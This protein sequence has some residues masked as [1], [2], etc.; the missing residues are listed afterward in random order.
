MID[1]INGFDAGNKKEKYFL[2]FRLGTLTLLEIKWEAKK[3]FYEGL[4]DTKTTAL[5]KDAIDLYGEYN[6]QFEDFPYSYEDIAA[7]SNFLGRQG[8]REY[9]GY[10][11]RDGKPLEEVFPTKYGAKAKQANKTP[12]EYLKITRPYYTRS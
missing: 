11:L 5:Q 3:R 6:M 9:F 7:L 12:E 10:V 4:K 2:E 8:A 1:W